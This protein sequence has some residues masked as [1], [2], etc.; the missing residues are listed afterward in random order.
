MA[1]IFSFKCTSCG[2]IHEGSPSFAFK[3]PDPWVEQS[4]EIRENGKL[5][6]DFCYYEDADG[7]HYFARVII[8]I[9]IHGIEE[10]FMWG[11]WVSL[12]KES[13]THYFEHFDEPEFDCFACH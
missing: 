11:V 4:D 1:A 5:G 10:G 8:E 2:E 9:P 12:S 13:Y 6:E 7:L 3:A